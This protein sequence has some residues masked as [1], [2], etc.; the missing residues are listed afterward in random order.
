MTVKT[1]A[2]IEDLYR[3]REDCKAEL[4]DGNLLLMQP[5]GDYPGRASGN[6]YISLR[7]YES[8]TRS[9]YA[10]S[11]NVG[12]RV[13]LP[14]RESFSPDASYFIG[15]RTGMKFL[16][17]APIFAAEVRSEGDYGPSAEQAMAAKRR[18]YFA[19]GTL[20]VWDID[21]LGEDV[22]RSYTSEN[23]ETP[24]VYRRGE[25]ATAIPA[26]PDWTFSVDDLF[27]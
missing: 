26:L 12:F 24:T 6:I 16:N 8:R 19:A 22:I 10:Y 18:D 3:V 7:Q 1:K 5:T 21:L 13:V 15:E 2:T 11:D 27:D 20:V 17:G 14:N 23:P 4:V 9:G 25:F